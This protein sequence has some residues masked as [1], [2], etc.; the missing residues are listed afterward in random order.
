MRFGD[1]NDL[2]QTIKNHLLN[3]KRQAIHYLRR[4]AL[5]QAIP[6]FFPTV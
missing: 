6:L 5:P 1:L 2:N 4:V 3:E